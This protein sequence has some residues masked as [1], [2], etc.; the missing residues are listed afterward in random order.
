MS[1]PAKPRGAAAPRPIDEPRTARELRL[2][3]ADRKRG[4]P[5]PSGN[6][7]RE[8]LR[9][10]RMPDPA[11]FVLFGGTGDLAHRKVVPALFQ[12]WRT[13]LLPHELAIVAIGRRPYEDEAFRAEL[14]ASLEQFSRVLPIDTAVWEE[15]AARIVYHRGNFGDPA[16]Y[17]GLAA[18]LGELDARQGTQATGSTTSPRSRPPSRRSSPA[19]APPG[20]TTS[21]T[22]AAG[23]GS[24]WRSRSGAT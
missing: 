14:R 6:P 17:D 23:G 18:R 9:L 21:S 13:N 4:A 16:L 10:E 24:S 1:R 5:K 7:L 2:A 19:S 22:A 8:G 11:V 12:L 3:R 20:S 15:F